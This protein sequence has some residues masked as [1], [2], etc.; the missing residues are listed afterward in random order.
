VHP[1]ARD[2][3][4]TQGISHPVRGEP[5]DVVRRLLAVQAQDYLGAK[6]SIG[7]RLKGAIDADVER[8]VN[9]GQILRTHILRPTWHFVLPEDIRWLLALTAPRVL[10]G[11]RPMER[12]LGLDSRTLDRAFKIITAELTGRR[13][14]TRVE[15]GAALVAGGVRPAAGQRLA[16][17]VMH[18][19]QVALICSG[20]R[21]GKQFT[22][23]LLDE[24][25]P[26]GL[27][28]KPMAR[29]DALAELGRRYFGS[30]GP[31]TVR[32]LAR[33]ASLTV[34]EATRAAEAARDGLATDRIAGREHFRSAE[35]P[36]R[37]RPN[38]RAHLLCIYDEYI[39]G[40]REREAIITPAHGKIITGRGAAVTN[41]VVIDGQILGTWSRTFGRDSAAI[42][43]D[44]FV[45]LTRTQQALI[46]EAAK[47]FG[48][49]HGLKP[50]MAFG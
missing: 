47:P 24:R 33:W 10:A 19:E 15:L 48:T 12:R 13:H 11:N 50:V 40:Y 29:A 8:A 21:R 5:A 14:R 3:L 43:V 37:G 26:P 28:A 2:R 46:R 1:V 39:A 45:R 22:Y 36:P 25:A 4:R 34:V 27:S 32:D 17:I 20:A 6:W 42:T 31:A 44:P 35:A 7:L 16:Y 23:A 9:D 30:R 38:R 18:A 49:F 41:V